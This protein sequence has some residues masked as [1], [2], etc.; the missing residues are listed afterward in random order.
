M[1]RRQLFS[2]A[3]AQLEAAAPNLA[4]TVAFGRRFEALFG[5]AR[6][7]LGFCPSCHVWPG[8]PHD[9]AG[10]SSGCVGEFFY[11]EVEREYAAVAE[12]AAAFENLAAKVCTN[13]ERPLRSGDLVQLFAGAV[14]GLRER[15]SQA[16]ST[17]HH[18][19]QQHDQ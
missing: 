6:S 19:E 4:A 5:V 18:G 7:V 13:R 14:A 11:G 10:D 12:I 8:Q 2:R 17:P 15:A 9:S 1:G 3:A 16:P